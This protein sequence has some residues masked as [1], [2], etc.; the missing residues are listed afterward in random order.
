MPKFKITATMY[1]YLDRGV[2]G[3]KDEDEAWQVAKEMDG[4]DFEKIPWIGDW[5]VDV[6]PVIGKKQ[7][8]F[9]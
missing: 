7:N 6:N 1:T 9:T 5:S 3:A 2:L 8:P 4:G